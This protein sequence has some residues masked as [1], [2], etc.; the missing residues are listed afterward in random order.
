MTVCESWKIDWVE[1]LNDFPVIWINELALEYALMWASMAIQ[2]SVSIGP[3]RTL[4]AAPASQ[5]P[6]KLDHTLVLA[7]VGDNT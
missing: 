5:F 3:A 1:N 6:N 7:A 2:L 4:N